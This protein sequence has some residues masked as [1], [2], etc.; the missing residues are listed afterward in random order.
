MTLI[1]RTKQ[2]ISNTSAPYLNK[3]DPIESRTGSIFLW[4]AGRNPT[5]AFNTS[6]EASSKTLGNLLAE[7]GNS[8]VGNASDFE[9]AYLSNNANSI[10]S[11]ITLKGGLHCI[12]TQTQD[13]NQ[14]YVGVRINNSLKT[15]L[16]TQV[17]LG[18]IYFSIWRRTTRKTNLKSGTSLSLI[19]YQTAF[20][21][22]T[23]T[24]GIELNV[25]GDKTLSPLL[26]QSNDDSI[27]VPQFVS[28]RPSGK[29]ESST[30]RMMIGAGCL[31]PWGTSQALNR[32]PSVIYYRIYIE[33]LALSGRSYAEVSALDQAE[34]NKAFAVGGRF[35]GDTW[36][37]PAT[38]LP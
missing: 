26:Y 31:P 24:Q 3:Y 20:L 14:N 6:A 28:A 17:A 7:Y 34:F 15:Y 33:N 38:V 2:N 13:T 4:D 5:T 19:N 21:A 32:S 8:V 11:E 22:H 25:G 27:G 16:D 23:N 37:D 29:S 12:A 36:S 1:L 9:R 35:Y 10:K 18:N 30:N